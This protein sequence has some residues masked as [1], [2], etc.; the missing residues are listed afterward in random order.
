MCVAWQDAHSD[1]PHRS[2]AGRV[3]GTNAMM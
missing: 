3:A 2:S 1:Q